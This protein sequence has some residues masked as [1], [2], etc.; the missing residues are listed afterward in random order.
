MC[1]F[2]VFQHNCIRLPEL[3]TVKHGKIVQIVIYLSF[4]NLASVTCAASVQSTKEHGT[5]KA[6][7]V[8]VLLH[9]P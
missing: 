3:S 8:Q 2:L 7:H 9:F 1:V 4:Q 5:M 6:K